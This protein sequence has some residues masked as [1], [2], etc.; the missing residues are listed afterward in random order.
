MQGEIG[1]KHI[2]S[3]IGRLF[4]TTQPNEFEI[5]GGS[6]ENEENQSDYDLLDGLISY[7]DGD[8]TSFSKSPGIISSLYFSMS[9]KIELFVKQEGFVI[10]DGLFFNQSWNYSDPVSIV[11]IEKK[12][13]NIEVIERCLI[14]SDAAF[15]GNKISA[16][17]ENGIYS[18]SNTNDS[19]GFIDLE[20]GIYD[21]HR[22]ELSVLINAE[23]V[24]LPGVEICRK[25]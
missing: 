22:I 15:K 3:L 10:C 2:G 24:K 16:I 21:V 7:N 1:V 6:N 8:L 18:S 23:N 19:F 5:W 20:N 25:S 9:T 13:F 4:L 12:N 17:K 11:A 14:I